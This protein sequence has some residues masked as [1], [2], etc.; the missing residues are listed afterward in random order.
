MQHINSRQVPPEA[1][2]IR[3]LGFS[4]HLLR[5]ASYTRTGVRWTCDPGTYHHELNCN[6]ND[7]ECEIEAGPL[8]ATILRISTLRLL[9]L[10]EYD[11]Q[12]EA[13]I[14]R[15]IATGMQEKLCALLRGQMDKP[16]NNF[17]MTGT[18]DSE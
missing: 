14:Q 5:R 18:I 3:E 7:E 11:E 16:N 1:R 2:L 6:E 15:M 13:S 12:L 4:R 9:K 10:M 8:G 17:S